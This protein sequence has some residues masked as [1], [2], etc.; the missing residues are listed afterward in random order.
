MTLLLVHLVVDY[1]NEEL[2]GSHTPNQIQ[3]NHNS[4]SEKWLRSRRAKESS[5][6]ID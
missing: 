2:F 4:K 6:F 1:E 5:K 3:W